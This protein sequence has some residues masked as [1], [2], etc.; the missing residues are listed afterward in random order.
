MTYEDL[1]ETISEILGNDKIQKK[2][3][4]LTYFLTE[5]NHHKMNEHLFYKSNPITEKFETSDEFEVEIDGLLI[6]FVKR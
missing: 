5:K 2:G 1:I 6:K 3:L 4:V